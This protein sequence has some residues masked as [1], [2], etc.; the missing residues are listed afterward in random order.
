M[1]SYDNVIMDTDRHQITND[2]NKILNYN[3]PIIFGNHIWMGCRNIILKGTEIA[4][5]CVIASGSNLRGKYLTQNCIITTS[6][7]I[8]KKE[9]R[10]KREWAVSR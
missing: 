2:N 5:G 3:R 10:W 7:T 9:I 1:W 8:L 4:D 6:N